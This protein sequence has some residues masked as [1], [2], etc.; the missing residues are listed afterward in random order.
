MFIHVEYNSTHG[1]C[2]HLGHLKLKGQI[3]VDY[4]RIEGKLV[5]TICESKPDI[6]YF[7]GYLTM[8]CQM[9]TI[10]QNAKCT[11]LHIPVHCNNQVH[12]TTQI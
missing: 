5:W 7:A 10:R 6:I 12:D 11:S 4:L 2:S 8:L 1:H 3:S 9:S